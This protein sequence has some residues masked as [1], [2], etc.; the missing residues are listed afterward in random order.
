MKELNI[1]VTMLANRVNKCLVETIIDDTQE[2][3]ILYR[4]I[5]EGIHK[6]MLYA[7]RIKREDQMSNTHIIP[8]IW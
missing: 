2:K 8:I 5:I 4:P 6:Q 7:T 1:D 3:F